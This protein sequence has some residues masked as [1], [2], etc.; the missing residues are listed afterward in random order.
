MIKHLEESLHESKLV[1]EEKHEIQD[2]VDDLKDIDNINTL[3]PRRKE[4]FKRDLMRIL[5]VAGG[6]ATLTGF[7][8]DIIQFFV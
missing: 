7:I 4:R 5:K 2:V 6:V 8:N 1:I 3:E